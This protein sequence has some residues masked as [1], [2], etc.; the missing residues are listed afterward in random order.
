MDWVAPDKYRADFPL[1][2]ASFATL[3]G[4]DGVYLFAAS[5]IGWLTQD[6]K[7]QVQLPVIYPQVPLAAYI[8]RNNL[9]DEGDFAIKIAV[10]VSSSSWRNPLLTLTFYAQYDQILN[11]Q[12]PPFANQN[13][14]SLRP[15][16]IAARSN[17][18]N[19][20]SIDPLSFYAGRVEVISIKEVSAGGW[21]SPLTST[22]LVRLSP[23]R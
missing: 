12:M 8:Y 3:Q 9:I 13:F 7:F 14:T 23:A 17:I 1:V 4:I 15:Q 11:V 20:S 6:G 19:V 21:N 16:G 2:A 18:T 22:A 5:T 10:T